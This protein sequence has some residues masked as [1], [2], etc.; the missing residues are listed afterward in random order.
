MSSFARLAQA[1][2]HN[3]LLVSLVG[4]CRPSAVGIALTYEDS[5]LDFPINSRE[6]YQL[7]DEPNTVCPQS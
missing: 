4:S 7:D 3:T 6:S 5:N 2:P 1:H